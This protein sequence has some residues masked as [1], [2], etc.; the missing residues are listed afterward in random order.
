[1]AQ[2]QDPTR[3]GHYPEG[4]ANRII[5]ITPA[6]HVMVRYVNPDGRETMALILAFGEANYGKGGQG[7]PV[8]PG[9]FIL[10]NESQLGAQ[11]RLAPIDHAKSIIAAMEDK[12][13]IVDGKLQGST[14]V[15]APALPD[16]SGVFGEIDD[17][18]KAEKSADKK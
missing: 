9:I 5:S 3:V 17:E 2:V 7:G 15:A 13:L 1:M 11:L 4:R 6:Q 12:G 14:P 10:A 18:D 8:L 16:V